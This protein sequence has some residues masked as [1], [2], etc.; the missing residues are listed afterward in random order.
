VG[1]FYNA[2]SPHG[3]AELTKLRKKTSSE[4]TY[5]IYEL[6]GQTH[7]D[8]IYYDNKDNDATSSAEVGLLVVSK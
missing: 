2:P 1:L 3:A 7:N 4:C 5:A 8:L 6:C